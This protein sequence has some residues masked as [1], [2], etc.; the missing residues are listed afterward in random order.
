MYLE[1]FGLTEPPFSIAPNPHYLYMSDQYLEA[2]A[3][4]MFDSG[5]G[6]ILLTGEVGTGKTTISRKMLENLSNNIDVAWIINPKL[7]VDE[8]LASICD[9][10]GITYPAG[11]SSIKIF[12]DLISEFLIQA[13]GHGRNVLLI[14]D[15]AQNLSP[16]VLEQL[17]LLTNLETNERKLLQIILLGQPELK[18]MLERN[19]LRQLAQRITA[20]YHLHSLSLN[21]TTEYIRHRLTIAGCRQSPF[22]ARTVK[23]IH[24]LSHGTPRLINLL[25]DRSLL[26]AYSCNHYIVSPN[27]VR[28]ASIEVLGEPRKS[29]T[30]YY[31]AVSIVLLALTATLL[32]PA[33]ELWKQPEPI[34]TTAPAK[35]APK[36]AP[37]N[38]VAKKTMSDT[39]AS[40]IDKP[41][42]IPEQPDTPTPTTKRS[43]AITSA[44]I[45]A[46][47]SI[48]TI[49]KKAMPDTTPITTAA[50]AT[51]T[52]EPST[53]I[54]TAIT[55]YASAPAPVESKANTAPVSTAEKEQLKMAAPAATPQAAIAIDKPATAPDQPDTS[56]PKTKL[57]SVMTSVKIVTPAPIKSKKLPTTN[58]TTNSI[59]PASKIQPTVWEAIEQ[60]GTQALAFSTLA[61]IWHS[62]VSRAGSTSCLD[63]SDKTLSCFHLRNNDWLLR[64]FNLPAVFS[65]QDSNG[66]EHFAVVHAISS[67]G[68]SIQLGSRQWYITLAA[69]KKH[70][71]K[72]LQLIWIKPP[73]AKSYL[74]PGDTGQTVEWL[75]KQMDYFGGTMIPPRRFSSLDPILVERIKDFQQRHGLPIDGTAGTMTLNRIQQLI[76][77]NTPRLQSIDILE[78]N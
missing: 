69:L 34:A 48:K 76:H 22:P 9:E 3:H 24:R 58:A 31:I 55:K 78:D 68:I 41:G 26:G 47:A 19:D 27:H 14:I 12:T 15:E 67:R 30:M 21:S 17:R 37:T 13:H 72:R 56:T 53:I 42:T 18:T 2:L 33:L 73:G 32:T 35:A 62:K 52:T 36:P 25:C 38:T 23:L 63:L 77:P 1:Y 5:G 29:K 57:S 8:L 50:T 39:T 65:L 74:K 75:A 10:L 66:I 49:A 59:T 43:P 20:R 16:E 7:S 45:V 28:Q 11:T 51:S 60:S 4:L 70:W 40:T 44:K 64:E 46:P 61:N 6:F 54:P 71:Q